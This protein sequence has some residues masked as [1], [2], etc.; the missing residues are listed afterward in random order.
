MIDGTQHCF[1]PYDLFYT[2]DTVSATNAGVNNNDPWLST[3]TNEFPLQ[4]NVN[5]STTCHGEVT[6]VAGS[7]GY[8]YCDNKLIP[9]TY[10]EN[11]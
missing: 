5:T 6:S 11:Y 2:A 3:W 1:T 8:S 4:N 9:K 10:T 7:N